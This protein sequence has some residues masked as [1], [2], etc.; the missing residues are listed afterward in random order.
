METNTPASTPTYSIRVECPPL[1]TGRLIDIVHS[2]RDKLAKIFIREI[3]VMG[4][5]FV[6][7]QLAVQ[8]LHKFVTLFS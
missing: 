4:R 7:N 3:V 2:S 1:S 8:Y 5:T 6:G